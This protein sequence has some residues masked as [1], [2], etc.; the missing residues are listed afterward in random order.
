MQIMRNSHN[1]L[2]KIFTVKKKRRNIYQNWQERKE[3]EEVDTV[4]VNRGEGDTSHLRDQEINEWWI[5]LRDFLM[6][7]ELINNS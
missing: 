2:S 6:I 4:M 3:I 7:D 1:Y 5:S